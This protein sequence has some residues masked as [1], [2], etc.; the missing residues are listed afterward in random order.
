MNSSST[1]IRPT[2][3]RKTRAVR[4]VTEGDDEL[5]DGII[6]KTITKTTS[7]GQV[8]ETIEVPVWIN[9]LASAP[10][11]EQSTTPVPNETM[12]N[13]LENNFETANEFYERDPEGEETAGAGRTQSHY[14]RQ[15]VDRVH[16]MLKALLSREVLPKNHICSCCT[17][18]KIAIW[19]CRD[20]T[21]ARMC[22]RGCIRQRH[23][24]CPTHRIEV[25]SG[26]YFR[27][28]ELWEAGLYVVVR[29]HTDPNICPALSFQINTLELFQNQRDADEERKLREGFSVHMDSGHSTAGKPLSTEDSTA[30]V[31]LSTEDHINQHD[32]S[33]D[34]NNE[35]LDKGL[36]MDIDD[37]ADFTHRLDS[38]YK[39]LYDSNEKTGET[40]FDSYA[41]DID[42]MGNDIEDMPPLPSNYIP[43]ATN[44]PSAAAFHSQTPETPRNDALNNP[45][46]RIIHTNGI[47]HIGV[48]YCTCRGMD[49]THSD[50]MAAGFVP[51]SFTR[52]RTFFTHAVLDDFRLSNLE[53]K[54]SAYQYFQKLRRQTS[55][56]SPDTV[57]NLYHELRRMSRLW[58]WMKKLKWAG[59][60]HRPDFTI[61][62]EPGELSNFCPACPQPGI[63]IP[64]NWMSEPER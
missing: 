39:K 40:T 58:R 45:Y 24:D 51:T 12:Q 29:H 25:W 3:R 47:H 36:D 44:D 16:P 31:P 64:E 54:A 37:D 1:N 11:T 9:E 35:H 10:T 53:C 28:A 14:I 43:A 50:L 6:L 20:C 27:A 56:M 13:P 18:N 32:Q 60:A 57:P 30:G 33:F 8:E 22:C 48:V 59:L 7:S 19:R 26:N 23:M 52:Y 4:H 41:D 2:K 17:N 61:D 55:P 34:S 38:I 46:I 15:F 21:A 49:M 5:A 63:N 42:I 62:P